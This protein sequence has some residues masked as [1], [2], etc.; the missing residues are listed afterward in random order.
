MS[1]LS[2]LFSFMIQGGGTASCYD[3][4]SLTGF[5][6]ISDSMVQPSGFSGISTLVAV[7]GIIVFDGS[8]LR[9]LCNSRCLHGELLRIL[10]GGTRSDNKTNSL[11]VFTFVLL[12]VQRL[13][14]M[15]LSVEDL[16]LTPQS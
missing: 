11:I 3:T 10:A 2:L 6:V 5:L 12:V 14:L 15:Y 13:V 9:I 16:G 4:K 1:Q 8:P 7:L